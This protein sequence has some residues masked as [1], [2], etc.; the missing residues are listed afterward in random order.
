MLQPPGCLHGAPAAH[1]AFN[2]AAV[3]LAAGSLPSAIIE[4]A[5]GTPLRTF[6]RGAS[7]LR[8]FR[9][10]EL[11]HRATSPV[12]ANDAAREGGNGGDAGSLFPQAMTSSPRIN[13]WTPS[14]G[15][16]ISDLRHEYCALCR[17]FGG[18]ILL[19]CTR[20]P[21][22]TAVLGAH[23]RKLGLLALGGELQGGIY[24]S[25]VS[26]LLLRALCLMLGPAARAGGTGFARRRRRGRESLARGWRAR[27][28][29]PVERGRGTRSCLGQGRKARLEGGHAQEGLS[30]GPRMVLCLT[31][32]SALLFG[33]NTGDV[34]VP[35]YAQYVGK[36]TTRTCN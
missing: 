27:R 9:S 31:C 26:R 8:A 22:P 33:R 17:G 32:R 16:G 25:L 36:S 6:V 11:A 35:W 10:T 7:A 3:Q 1:A 20:A 34:D 18:Y 4:R 28:A 30:R 23:D 15:L 14:N 19:G 29:G 24:G 21:V 13:R 2:L 12:P 5:L